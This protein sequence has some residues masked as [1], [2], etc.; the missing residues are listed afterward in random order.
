MNA[1]NDNPND[2]PFDIA[3]GDTR[4]PGDEGDP[5]A[6][7]FIIIGRVT[8]RRGGKKSEVHVMLRAPDDD[9]AVRETLN[10]LS[11]EGYAEA[12]LDQIGV[13]DGVPA[14][15]P[16]ASAYQGVLDGEVAIIAHD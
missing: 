9:Y 7:V 11:R 14:D 4:E 16:H 10:A 12:E 8:R 15:E 2:E 5:A 13:L 6:T 1:D 3:P